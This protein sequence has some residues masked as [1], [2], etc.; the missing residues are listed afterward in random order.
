MPIEGHDIVDNQT[1]TEPKDEGNN[2]LDIRIFNWICLIVVCIGIAGWILNFVVG[3][4]TVEFFYSI[5]AIFVGGL[6]W[7]LSTQHGLS[8]YLRIPLVLFFLILLGGAWFTNQGFEGSVPYYI[9]I[10]GNAVV[11]IAPATYR[12]YLFSFVVLSI[13][14]LYVVTYNDPAL[15][16][17]YISS[18]VRFLDMAFSFFTCFTL[19]G[20]LSWLVVREYEKEKDKNE[21]LVQRSLDDKTRLEQLLSEISVL[22]GILPVCSFCK[23]I[24]DE[25]DQWQSM[26]HY[27]SSH[28]EAQFSH[29]FCPDCGKEH[30]NV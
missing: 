5:A 17:D 27:I 15:V 11:I 10:L 24:R 29:G 1:F 6:S 4:P 18:D 28:S 2:A 14:A 26:E 7:Y 23:K 19:S 16:S 22:K 8:R 13:L 12:W 25:N 30:Y 9:F 20:V 3:N 21:Q